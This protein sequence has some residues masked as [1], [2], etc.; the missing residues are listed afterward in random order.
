MQAPNDFVPPPSLMPPDSQ[1]PPSSGSGSGSG[2][3]E[4]NSNSKLTPTKS[5]KSLIDRYGLSSRVPSSADKGKG[6]E[7]NNGSQSDTNAVR[8]T[9]GQGENG[10]LGEKGKWEASKEARERGL[11]E[12]KEKMI[13][14]ARRWVIYN[15]LLPIPPRPL[16]LCARSALAEY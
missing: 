2:S 8:D 16:P 11:R 12:R 13:L 6:K 10:T 7:V 5:G 9:S 4:T 14:E 1:P 3:G 15:S